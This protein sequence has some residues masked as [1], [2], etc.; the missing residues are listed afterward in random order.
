MAKKNNV[1]MD[2]RDIASVV[3]K[4]LNKNTNKKKKNYS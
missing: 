2:G 3:L 4:D 1:V